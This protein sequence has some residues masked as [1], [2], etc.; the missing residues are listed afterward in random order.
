[1]VR[2]RTPSVFFFSSRRR[3]TRSTRDWSSDVCSSDLTSHPGLA[4]REMQNDGGGAPDT[5]QMHELRERRPAA[6]Y[7]CA[8]Y[9]V[10]VGAPAVHDQIGRASCRERV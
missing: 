3:H 4:L 5:G 7:G 8:R 6:G 1:M 10:L 9:L 2:P